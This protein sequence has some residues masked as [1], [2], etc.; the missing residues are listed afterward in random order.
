MA[1]LAI[2]PEEQVLSQ[3]FEVDVTL[4]LDF[5][6]GARAMELKI[7]DYRNI[8]STV[9]QL[10][11]LQVCFVE[12][13]QPRSQNRYLSPIAQVQVRLSKPAAPIPD[14]PAKLPLN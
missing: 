2:W 14:L 8:I 1:T 9:Q 5:S 12:R 13:R 6:R 11:K 3:W 4:W 7:L 10:V